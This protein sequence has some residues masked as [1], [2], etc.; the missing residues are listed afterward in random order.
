M[1]NEKKRREEKRRHDFKIQKAS[2]TTV[3]SPTKKCRFL[4]YGVTSAH[5]L[6]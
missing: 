4:H 6:H 3:D 5:R 2:S 1:R